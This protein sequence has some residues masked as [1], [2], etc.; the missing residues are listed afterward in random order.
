MQIA[1]TRDFVLFEG[2]PAWMHFH[3]LALKDTFL[4]YQ[5]SAGAFD[6]WYWHCTR[7]SVLIAGAVLLL[8]SRPSWEG[9]GHLI[10]L[11]TL[12]QVR[13]S[14]R[15]IPKRKYDWR[16]NMYLE[17]PFILRSSGKTQLSHGWPL[18]VFLSWFFWGVRFKN[19]DNDRGWDVHCLGSPLPRSWWMKKKTTLAQMSGFW[20]KTQNPDD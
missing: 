18:A 5:G 12:Y 16:P 20:I 15:T 3:V 6:T 17:W 1:V 9:W 13:L 8:R 10:N 7:L 14:T 2:L 11:R 19:M 4:R